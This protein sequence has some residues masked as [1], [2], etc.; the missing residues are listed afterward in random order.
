VG[1][2]GAGK[3]LNGK[4]LFPANISCHAVFVKSADLVSRTKNIFHIESPE[5][6]GP[7]RSR[8]Q[9]ETSCFFQNQL[10]FF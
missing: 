4:N 9:A 8:N 7:F 6:S 5:K 1:R 3:L 10:A 2:N